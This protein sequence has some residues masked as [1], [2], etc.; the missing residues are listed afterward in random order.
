MGVVQIETAG[1]VGL[2]TMGAGIAEVLARAGLRVHAVE[3]DDTLL[4][5]GRGRIEQSLQRAA[6][7]GRLAADEHRATLE[8]V[9]F[10]TGRGDL[11]DAD[12][13]IEAVPERLDIKASLFREVDGSCPPE[14]VLATNTSSLSVTAIAAATERPGRVIGLHFFNPAPV[15]RLVEIVDT[16]L[17]D[18]DVVD[19][20]RALVERC[21]KTPVAVGDRAG[22]VA[23]A[24]LLPYLNHAARIVETG[25]ASV[26]S[27]D[28][29]MTELAGLPM[30]PLALMDLIGLDVCLPILDVLWDE[31]RSPRYAAAP[32]LRRLTTAGHLGRKA[33]RG[34]YSYGGAE[35]A[36]AIGPD[37]DASYDGTDLLVAHLAD[38]VRMSED[39]YATTDDIDTAMR[40]GCG[41]PRGPFALLESV[42]AEVEAAVRQAA[43]SR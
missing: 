8:R 32:L 34:W 11:A 5:A 28:A 6:D 42:G 3:L 29:A 12:L 15:M 39:R 24:L 35:P 10:T 41:Y 19:A 13:V 33:G 20:A 21:G 22:F 27:V 30:G 18:A 26:A 23:N 25:Q 1:V 38:A 17:V 16:V 14:T 40:L 2:G 31:F 9:H 37:T 43:V 7:R 4:A 36:P